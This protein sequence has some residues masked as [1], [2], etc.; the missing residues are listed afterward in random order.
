MKKRLGFWILK[1]C[2]ITIFGFQKVKKKK[3]NLKVMF[4]L[5]KYLKKKKKI[6]LF[7]YIKKYEI[8]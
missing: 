2:F 6:I 3:K 5:I 8:N 4:D 7:Y 1:K